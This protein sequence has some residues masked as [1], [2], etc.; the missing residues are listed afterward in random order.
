MAAGAE[1][2]L[3]TAMLDRLKL[4]EDRIEGVCRWS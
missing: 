3:T 4:D 1:K 2:G